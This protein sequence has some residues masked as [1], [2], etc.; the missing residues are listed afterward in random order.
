MAPGSHSPVHTCDMLQ[1][2]FD[3]YCRCRA[4]CW[5][6]VLRCATV[7]NFPDNVSEGRTSN[8][9]GVGIPLEGM[10]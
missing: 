3:V 5:V 2:A 4:G 6:S 9:P 1:G 7:R 8:C 10:E